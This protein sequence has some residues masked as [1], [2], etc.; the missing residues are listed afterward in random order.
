MAM[1]APT[2]VAVMEAEKSVKQHTKLTNNYCS[3]VMYHH[4]AAR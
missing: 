1:A 4:G 2:A 3:A